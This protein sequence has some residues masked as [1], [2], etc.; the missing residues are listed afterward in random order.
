MVIY[1]SLNEEKNKKDSYKTP[2]W[3]ARE[4]SPDLPSLCMSCA[5]P[6]LHFLCSR[7]PPWDADVHAP[8]YSA[9]EKGNVLTSS[10]SP[11]FLGCSKKA[12]LCH[13]PDNKLTL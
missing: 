9:A 4:A 1:F 13:C 6:E 2:S 8:E 11:C 3:G 12:K 10:A 7:Q 5:F